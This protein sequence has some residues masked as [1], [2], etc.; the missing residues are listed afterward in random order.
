[1]RLHC[2]SLTRLPSS[3]K[4]GDRQA[5]GLAHRGQQVR[6]VAI[7]FQREGLRVDERDGLRIPVH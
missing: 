2:Q 3:P 4:V 1:M 5:V 7:D 6:P